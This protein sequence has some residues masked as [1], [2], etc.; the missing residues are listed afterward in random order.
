[1]QGYQRLADSSLDW[2]QDLPG[3]KR[4]LGEKHGDDREPFFFSYF[5]TGIPEHYGIESRRLP[6]FPEWR[7]MRVFALAPGT[8]AISATMYQNLYTRYFGPWNRRYEEEYQAIVSTL[9]L[10]AENTRDTAAL[11]EVLQSH[12]EQVW[13]AKYAAFEQLRF[14]RLCGWLRATQRPPDATVGHSILIWQLDTT[15]LHEALWGSPR[16]LYEMPATE[17]PSGI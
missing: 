4:W 3:L 6:G 5:G 9:G 15:A 8:Y 10:T 12:P 2:G 13:Q 17:S 1:V 11:A 14:H 16:E 7:A